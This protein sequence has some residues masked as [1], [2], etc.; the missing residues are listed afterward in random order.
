MTGGNTCLCHR[1]TR[2]KKDNSGN[3]IYRRKSNSMNLL[4]EK[5]PRSLA[6]DLAKSVFIRVSSLPELVFSFLFKIHCIRNIL[7]ESLKEDIFLYQIM[8]P[9]WKYTDKY[10]RNDMFYLNLPLKRALRYGDYHWF[11]QPAVQYPV[12]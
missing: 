7:T 9:A 5:P 3:V 10:R 11:C 1:V 6:T 12:Y 2:Y 8:L 4:A